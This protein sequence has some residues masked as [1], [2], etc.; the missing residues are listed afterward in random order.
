MVEGAPQ[1]TAPP[2]AQAVPEDEAPAE[3]PVAEPKAEPAA[4]EPA[5]EAPPGGG[6]AEPP[7]VEGAMTGESPAEA[8]GPANAS[9]AAAAIEE[10][11]AV[12]T[13]AG[14]VAD[15]GATVAKKVDEAASGEFISLLLSKYHGVFFFPKILPKKGMKSFLFYYRVFTAGRRSQA[16]AAAAAEAVGV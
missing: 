9:P 4:K 2:T 15:E 8:K 12:E 13:V 1:P 6:G 5:V 7:G 10:G 16:A 14:V 3:L 11:S